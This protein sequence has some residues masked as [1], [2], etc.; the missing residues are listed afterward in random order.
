MVLPTFPK[1]LMDRIMGAGEGI[2][3]AVTGDRNASATATS[4]A[5][6]RAVEYGIRSDQSLSP[7]QRSQLMAWL[8]GQP[9]LDP[10]LVEW[11]NS[12]TMGQPVEGAGPKAS[13]P[14]VPVAG[15]QIASGGGI[16][17]GMDNGIGGGGPQGTAAA[18]AAAQ[19]AAQKVQAKAPPVPNATQT[20]PAPNLPSTG[21]AGGAAPAAGA[22]PGMKPWQNDDSGRALLDGGTDQMM[23]FIQR[24][25]GL[26]PERGGIASNFFAKTNAPVIAAL[27]QLYDR[28]PGN[29][30]PDYLQVGD[31]FANFGKKFITPGQSGLATARDYA[32]QIAGD[33]EFAQ[34]LG[35]VED[36][37]QMAALMNLGVLKNA[38]SRGLRKAWES[39]Q[40]QNLINRYEDGEMGLMP[41][42]S[43]NQ[44]GGSFTKF[45]AANP[46]LAQQ[47]FGYMPR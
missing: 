5:A 8:Q 42:S 20:P 18:V 2:V 28:L 10:N 40:T 35:G 16:D 1:F 34:Y 27:Q 46:Q 22:V 41:G 45:L 38:G 29:S 7:E 19:Q 36:T 21:N 26:D 3:N 6:R 39:R 30:I 24:E 14:V 17:A 4:G 43:Y 44:N 32:A 37:D 31:N 33:G 25:N 12:A 47:L 13:G 15:N 9:L 11:V 23:R